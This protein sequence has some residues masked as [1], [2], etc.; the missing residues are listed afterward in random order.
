MTLAWPLTCLV[1]VTVDGKSVR[2][3]V[4]ELERIRAT[5]PLLECYYHVVTPTITNVILVMILNAYVMTT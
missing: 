2:V 3:V 4:V 5:T 1:C